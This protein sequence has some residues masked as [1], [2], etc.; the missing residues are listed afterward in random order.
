MSNKEKM[1]VADIEIAF[2]SVNFGGATAS[3]GTKEAQSM[4]GELVNES[5]SP[6]VDCDRWIPFMFCCAYGFAKKL[7]RKRPPGQGSLPAKVFLENTRFLM[8][9]IAIAETNNLDIIKK[10]NGKDGYVYICEDYA[11]AALEKVYKRLS[12]RDDGTE[13]TVERVMDKMISEI[14][15]EQNPSQKVENENMQD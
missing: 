1:T 11:Y 6:F 5:W 14:Q 4:M 12:T 13:S 15:S 3:G 8:R 2:P 7:T 9:A 10:P